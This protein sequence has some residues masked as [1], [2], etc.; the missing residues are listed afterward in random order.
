MPQ[1]RRSSRLQTSWPGG[2][3]GI[4]ADLNSTIGVRSKVPSWISTILEID[5]CALFL[6]FLFAYKKE[7]N[8]MVEWANFLTPPG[9]IRVCEELWWFSVFWA[10]L[11]G[12]SIQIE[13]VL[14]SR[15]ATPGWEIVFWVASTSTWRIPRQQFHQQWILGVCKSKFLNI[16]DINDTLHL[17]SISQPFCIPSKMC[18]WL[19]WDFYFLTESW[20]LAWFEE[21][22]LQLEYVRHMRELYLSKAQAELICKS[23]VTGKIVTV[24]WSNNCQPMSGAC[25]V[26]THTQSKR[27]ERGN[28]EIKMEIWN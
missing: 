27:N 2:I 11:D 12:D 15:L 19:F 4:S 3:A 9:I 6:G 10:T 26:T 18:I 24:R 1:S 23:I 7:H 21:M 8:P 25:E 13:R 14:L 20:I 16:L 17:F 22:T 28:K 5:L